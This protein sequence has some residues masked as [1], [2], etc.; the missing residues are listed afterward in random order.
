[1]QSIIFT[2]RTYCSNNRGWHRQSC[3][4]ALAGSDP[5]RISYVNDAYPRSLRFHCDSIICVS[6]LFGHAPEPLAGHARQMD[7]PHQNLH[8]PRSTP[9]L[10][11]LAGTR[12]F[13]VVLAGGGCF[14][15]SKRSEQ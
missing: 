15:R 7:L 14:P 4:C 12:L 3:S 9:E 5:V 11:R 6:L 10:A 2:K 8:A 1:M 13:N